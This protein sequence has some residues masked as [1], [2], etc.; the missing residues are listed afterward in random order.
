MFLFFL[1]S[2]ASRRALL[3]CILLM[4]Y[5]L[6][7]PCPFSVFFVCVRLCVLDLCFCYFLSE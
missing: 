7:P 5:K 3:A 1:L 6:S 2:Q 4:V